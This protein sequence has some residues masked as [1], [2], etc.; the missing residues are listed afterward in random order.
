[1]NNPEATRE[2]LKGES[3]VN[4]TYIRKE[5]YQLED[6]FRHVNEHS[7][8]DNKVNFDGDFIKMGSHRYKTF[9]Y[10]GITCV[11]CGIEGQYFAKERF[12]HNNLLTYHFNM[13]AVKPDGTEVLMTKDHRIPKS[14]GG[15]DTLDNYQTMCTRCNSKKADNLI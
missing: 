2:L 3:I 15:T 6:I 5:V 9:K 4:N 1:M 10:K 7:T 11:N 14:K 8:K 13:Y 12:N